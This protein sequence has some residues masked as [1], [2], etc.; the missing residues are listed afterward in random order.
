[1]EDGAAAA[2]NTTSQASR[3]NIE[4]SATESATST[5]ATTP[6]VLTT[7]PRRSTT[8]TETTLALQNKAEGTKKTEDGEILAAK[9][10]QTSDNTREKQTTAQTLTNDSSATGIAVSPRR[11]VPKR[12]A[13]QNADGTKDMEEGAAAIA[14]TTNTS[15][16]SGGSQTTLQTPTTENSANAPAVS[17]TATTQSM[18]LTTPPRRSTA[19]TDTTLAI[20]NNE[21]QANIRDGLH[22]TEEKDDSS[23]DT[24]QAGGDTPAVPVTPEAANI[25]DPTPHRHLMVRYDVKLAL[26]PSSNPLRELRTKFVTFL[27][28]IKTVC[29]DLVLYPWADKNNIQGNRKLKGLSDFD[30]DLPKELNKI[31][32]YLN[33]AT[34]DDRGKI[35]YGAG[36]YLGHNKETD[37]IVK[38]LSFWFNQ[39]KYGLFIRS[40]QADDVV[41][42]GWALYSFQWLNANMLAAEILKTEGLTIGLRHKIIA[43]RQRGAMPPEERIKAFHFEVKRKERAKGERIFKRLYSSEQTIFPLGLCLRFCPLYTSL[44]SMEVCAKVDRLRY[45]Q[46]AFTKHMIRTP[47]NTVRNLYW[48]IRPGGPT[49]R[50]I[51]M[52]IMCRDEPDMTLWHSVDNGRMAGTV[53]FTYHPSREAE[54]KAMIAGLLPYLKWRL[55]D[56]ARKTPRELEEWFESRIYPY[57]SDEARELAA[58][59]TWDPL[60]NRVTGA[61]DGETDDLLESDTQFAALVEID[62]IEEVN[63]TIQRPGETNRDESVSTFQTRANNTQQDGQSSGNNS[64]STLGT[65]ASQLSLSG[66]AL[67]E[68]QQ[69]LSQILN[70]LNTGQ[71]TSL[72]DVRVQLETAAIAASTEARSTGLMQ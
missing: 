51:L 6:M 40:L 18:V 20:R 30:R 39:N 32:A 27:K 45:R 72:E 70:R 9:T 15:N 19:T 44:M 22:V 25:P 2:A 28:K 59:S 29:P 5:T 17:E 69:H 36:I 26:D 71:V 13:S 47:T 54:A 4:S 35:I 61:V 67:R 12:Q 46:R 63:A 56:S 14:A 10:N 21:G 68:T 55:G 53:L 49:L 50:T 34:P 57:F 1:M 41:I 52:E 64:S 38:E 43:T 58:D 31:Q 62:N 7:P 42:V 66:A 33:D 23:V 48:K 16:A 11:S 65:N 3:A 8:T 60:S 37:E 24:Q